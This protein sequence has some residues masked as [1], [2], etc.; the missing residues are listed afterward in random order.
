MAKLERG[1][2]FEFTRYQKFLVGLLAFLQFTIVLDFM[3]LSPLG[4]I[5][6]PALNLST[7]QFGSVVSAYAF[8][9]GLSGFLAAGFAD[10]FDRK[11]LLLFFYVG[12]VVG[13]LFCAL[14]PSFIF[15]LLARIVTGIF[16]GVIGS[17][18]YAIVADL[19]PSQMRGR[20]MGVVQTAF[21]AAQILGIPA[22]L[23]FSGKWG[24]H[25]PFLMIVVV[26]SLVTFFIVKYLKPIDGHLRLHVDRPAYHHLFE[27]L[28]TRNYQKAFATMALLS[29]GGFMIMPFSS[30]FSVNNL[31]VGL[32]QLPIVYMI[33]G[34]SSILMGPWMGRLSDSFGKYRVFSLGSFFGIFL[35][36]YYTHLGASP[37][38]LVVLINVV[39][40]ATI[41]SRMISSNAL[42]S[43]IPDVSHRGSFMSINSSVQ[44][45][46][47]GLASV[48]A[49]LIVV[50]EPAGPLVHFDT[51]GYLVALAMLATW[52]MLHF[53]RPS[54]SQD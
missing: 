17:I 21:A 10:R 39:M 12:F 52:I 53:L 32:D 22:G 42:I 46:S 7:A 2:D 44:Q 33:T 3:I 36:L 30:A 24:W 47:G 45:L 20:V 26:S 35:I 18:V 48:V 6:M 38:W 31:K 23:F 27:T 4:A 25:A 9:A 54:I 40:F 16:A 8:A 28:S 15:L 29:T 37:L 43:Q 19:F 13:T 41:S 49:G 34:V 11:K 5:L 51:L 14:A 50:Q 1:L